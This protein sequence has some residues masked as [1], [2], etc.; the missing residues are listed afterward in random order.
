MTNAMTSGAAPAT[1][2]ALV[3][4]GKMG[5]LVEQLAPELGFA[6]VA[7]LTGRNN[8]GGAGIEPAALAGAQ[9]AIDFSTPAAVPDNAVRLAALKIPQVIGTTG[10]LDALP[11][12]EQAVR[13]HGT[14]LVHG[15]N[16]SVGVLVFY[17]IVE[18]AARL[19][20][21]DADYDPWL[22][23]IHHRLKKDAPS[24]TLKELARLLE[25]AGYDGSV[26]AASSRAGAIP[27]THTVGFDSAADTITLTHAARDRSGFARGALKAARFILGRTGVHAW[28]D[29]WSQTGSQ[30]EGADG[31]KEA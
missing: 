8:E 31:R 23:E 2:L 25:R 13:E 29:V 4:Y 18:A 30:T 28:R 5:R 7:R 1:K 3:G 10:W 9:V 15:A 12:V 16:F 6:V 14:G 22:Y 19:F 26:D 21:A 11:R 17:Q 24:G 27:G 20:A